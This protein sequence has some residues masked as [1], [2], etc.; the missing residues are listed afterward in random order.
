MMI[1]KW[2]AGLVGGRAV[3]TS[4]HFVLTACE[5]ISGALMNTERR[6]KREEKRT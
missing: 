4:F 2:E 1:E 5:L 3:K 6:L